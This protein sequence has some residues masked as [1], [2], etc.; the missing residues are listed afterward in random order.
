MQQQDNW[1]KGGNFG[2]KDGFKGGKGGKEGWAGGGGGKGG[3]GKGTHLGPLV[4]SGLSLVES[5][6]NDSCLTPPP[7]QRTHARTHTQGTSKPIT[8]PSVLVGPIPPKSETKGSNLPLIL[9]KVLFSL[10]P[11]P[12]RRTTTHKTNPPPPQALGESLGQKVGPTLIVGLEARID[13]PSYNVEERA[14]KKEFF[15][16]LGRKIYIHKNDRIQIPEKS[17]L[18]DRL[19]SVRQNSRGGDRGGGRDWGRRGGSEERRGGGDRGGRGGY[20]GRDGGPSR[21][22][23]GGGRDRDYGRDRERDRDRESRHEESGGGGGGG[24][25][26]TKRPRPGADAEPSSGS[27][28]RPSASAPPAKYTCPKCKEKGQH[29]VKDCPTL[30]K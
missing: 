30:R 8:R 10:T 13:V 1:G 28:A 18:A 6:C 9:A 27:S 26:G 7:S 24:S 29:W 3:K 15:V 16:C 17:F 5:V 11:S 21:G 19:D 12:P 14:L 2:G 20:G 22:G 23:G 25:G 4:A